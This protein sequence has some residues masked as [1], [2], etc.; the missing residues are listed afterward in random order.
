MI[1]AAAC[2]RDIRLTA[3]VQSYHQPAAAKPLQTTTAAN[4]LLTDPRAEAVLLAV[5]G[6][7][8]PKTKPQAQ[9]QI[10][11]RRTFFL[12]LYDTLSWNI[13]DNLPEAAL[14]QPRPDPRPP[15]PLR[16]CTRSGV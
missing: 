9:S 13:A 4:K 8:P 15:A 3:P 1:K 12:G 16:L 7:N 14:Q 6:T 2:G 5:R 10:D 11:N